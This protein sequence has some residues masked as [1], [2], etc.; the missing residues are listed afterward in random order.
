MKIKSAFSILFLNSLSKLFFFTI[1]II[2]ARNYEIEL[3]GLYSFYLALTKLLETLSK[4]GC[5]TYALKVSK[6]TNINREKSIYNALVLSS[7][8][9]FI[10]FIL[11]SFIKP[12]LYDRGYNNVLDNDYL[13]FA[14]S[15]ISANLFILSA[16]L[17]GKLNPFIAIFLKEFLPVSL[18]FIFVLNTQDLNLNKLILANTFFIG[19]S[20]IIALI[21]VYASPKKQKNIT[22]GALKINE[23]MRLS[24]PFYITAIV[25]YV[26]IWADILILSQYANPDELGQYRAISQVTTLGV[27]VITAFNAY[28]NPIAIDHFNNKRI[29]LLSEAYIRIVRWMLYVTLPAFLLV[30]L[31][32]D[33]ILSLYK[34]QSSDKLYVVF[35]LLT[36]AQISN[37]IFGASGYTLAFTDN[38]HILKR[39]SILSLFVGLFLMLV[40]TKYIGIV[41]MA[42]SILLLVIFMN[43]INVISLKKA[44]I[45]TY[46]SSL[47]TLLKPIFLCTVIGLFIQKTNLPSIQSL[48]VHIFLFFSI[49]LTYFIKYEYQEK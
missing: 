38:E 7:I 18:L 15:F 6:N 22:K 41:G 26:L 34:I 35:L 28:Y 14:T 27:V 11:F 42:T 46:D 31:N 44:G 9:C 37:V 48:M 1:G 45:K 3:L 25:Q 30:I 2:L 23:L 19:I 32:I 33:T 5:G 43:L 36:L 12:F 39:N 49:F 8:L 13:I 24:R 10:F 40:L 20:F 29:D 47:F 4:H 21:L 17:Q 16:F